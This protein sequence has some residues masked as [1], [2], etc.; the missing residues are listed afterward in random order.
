MNDPWPDCKVQSC[1][2]KTCLWAGTGKCHPH[3][4]EELGEPE[5]NKR[6]RD[7]RAGD[8]SDSFDAFPGEVPEGLWES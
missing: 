6:Y 5:M 4:V 2:N 3:S 1:K 8:G 7:T